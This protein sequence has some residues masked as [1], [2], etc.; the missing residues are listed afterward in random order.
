MVRLLRPINGCLLLR[1]LVFDSSVTGDAD[2]AVDGRLTPAPSEAANDIF[3][4]LFMRLSLD[5]T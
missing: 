2:A 1:G 3:I 5:C 4:E